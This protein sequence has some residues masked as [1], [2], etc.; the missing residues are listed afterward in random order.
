MEE[1]M[2]NIKEFIF[3]KISKEDYC[4]IIGSDKSIDDFA[5]TFGVKVDILMKDLRIG[6]KTKSEPIRISNNDT[7]EILMFGLVKNKDLKN[8]LNAVKM[9][10]AKK[11][12]TENITAIMLQK[13]HRI[14]AHQ[15]KSDEEKAELVDNIF[16]LPDE[17]IR[18]E[19]KEIM[20]NI[21]KRTNEELYKG[22]S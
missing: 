2:D 16:D 4:I 6:G 13:G 11:E 19:M 20:D 12:D 5:G 7:K 9:S 1:T 17:E 18:N 21:K 15:T 3:E 14:L 8:V 22:Y 10:G